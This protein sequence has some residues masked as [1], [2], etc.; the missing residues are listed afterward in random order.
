MPEPDKLK[1]FGIVPASPEE[2]FTRYEAPF[3]ATYVEGHKEAVNALQILYTVP[4]GKTLYMTSLHICINSVASGGATCYIR[5]DTD[6][7]VMEIISMTRQAGETISI[8]L[9]F[10]IAYVIPEK[11]DIMIYSGAAVLYVVAF[12]IGYLR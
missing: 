5:N 11:Y 4:D 8:P 1:Q 6:V 9:T 12:F 3:G 7:F 2:V 10:P